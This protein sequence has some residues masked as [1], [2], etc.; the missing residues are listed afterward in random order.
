M[1]SQSQN[2]NAP[3]CGH[4]LAQGRAGKGS[5]DDASLKGRIGHR[6][7]QKLRADV[8]RYGFSCLQKT[9]VTMVVSW[10]VSLKNNADDLMINQPVET[11]VKVCWI[12]FMAAGP[13]A[14]YSGGNGGRAW[15]TVASL[16]ER[17]E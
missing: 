13:N 2:N 8:F 17:F 5:I 9:C 4:R 14:R 7:S 10:W 1:A 15:I 12:H 6:S 11:V 16:P 3:Q